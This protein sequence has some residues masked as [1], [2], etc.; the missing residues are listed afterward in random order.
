[1]AG[2]MSVTFETVQESAQAARTTGEEYIDLLNT[3]EQRVMGMAWTG[4]ARDSFD[5]FFT[6]MKSQLEPIR[7]QFEQLGEAI[8]G[9]GDAMQETDESIASSFGS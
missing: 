6:D 9:A 8:Q 2:E 4:A 1:M 3:L 5:N 7:E